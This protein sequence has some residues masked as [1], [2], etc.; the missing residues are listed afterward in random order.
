[1]DPTYGLTIH[2]TDGTK[3]SYQFPEQAQNEAHRQLRLEEFMKSPYLLVVGDGVLTMFP[4]ANI[5]AIQIPV[6]EQMK[7]TPLPKH[8]IKGASLVRGDL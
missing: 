2:F 7:K 8:V 1:M 3:I 4:V 6:S 5:K